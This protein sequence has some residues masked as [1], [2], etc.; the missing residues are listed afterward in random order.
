MGTSTLATETQ[1]RP[2]DGAALS[3]RAKTSG[4]TETGAELS[5]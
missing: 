4:D 3:P 2:T 1:S 5:A